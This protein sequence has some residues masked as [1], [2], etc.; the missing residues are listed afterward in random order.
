MA[1]SQA[2]K[3]AFLAEHGLSVSLR[4]AILKLVWWWFVFGR[5]D[6]GEGQKQFQN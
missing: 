1:F 2:V 6:A 4:L 5:Q 3:G